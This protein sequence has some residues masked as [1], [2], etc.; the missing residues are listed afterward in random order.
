MLCDEKNIIQNYIDIFGMKSKAIDSSL[1][2]LEAKGNLINV[3]I[4]LDDDLEPN[5]KNHRQT[6]KNYKH[7]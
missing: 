2:H 3:I 4:V 6:C 5:L 1:N 7:L